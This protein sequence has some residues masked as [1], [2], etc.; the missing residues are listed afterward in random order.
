MCS[1]FQLSNIL[2]THNILEGSITSGFD[3]IEAVQE[4]QHFA[5]NIITSMEHLV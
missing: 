2:W 1:L 4:S 3:C 5:S